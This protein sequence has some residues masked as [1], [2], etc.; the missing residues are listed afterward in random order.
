M[1]PIR[2]ILTSGCLF[3]VATLLACDADHPT[4]PG[5]GTEYDWSWSRPREIWPTSIWEAEDGT[6]WLADIDG[7]V[8]S[9]DGRAWLEHDTGADTLLHSIWTSGD[10]VYAVGDEGLILHYDGAA[11]SSTSAP[12]PVEL[13]EVW[14]TGPDDVWAVG[15]AGTLLHL[16]D[17][18]WQYHAT[19]N[20]ETL[21]AVWGTG[22]DDVY[23]GGDHGALYHFDGET[24]APLQTDIASTIWDLLG[25]DNGHLY[26]AAGDVWVR[27]AE[28]WTRLYEDRYCYTLAAIDDKLYVR[29]GGFLGQLVDNTLV[30]VPDQPGT[31]CRWLGRS[32]GDRILTV[33]ELGSV[34]AFQNEWATLRRGELIRLGAIEGT[35]ASD[36]YAVGQEGVVLHYDGQEWLREH[37]GTDRDLYAVWCSDTGRVFAVGYDVITTRTHGSWAVESS[38]DDHWLR[39]V[40]GLA[41]DDVY[42]GGM[43]GIILHYDGETW[44]PMETP[45]TSTIRGIWGSGPDDIFAVTR[46]YDGEVLHYD[47]Q[48]W[49]IQDKFTDNPLWSVWGTG[50]DNVYT[51]GWDG[52][53]IYHYDGE[54]W[55]VEHQPWDAT[56]HAVHG[57]GPD[58]VYVGGYQGG[59]WH[60]DGTGW[61]QIETALFEQ[62]TPDI[63]CAPDGQVFVPTS[64]G[65]VLRYGP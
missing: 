32:R 62:H 27:E 15:H 19:D 13:W 43:S 17:G 20:F 37:S 1:K 42:A 9:F 28:T 50:P 30:V 41:D 58:N 57:T 44:T 63:W 53:A 54:T 3:L 4:A 7:R 10:H 24:I 39:A 38:V 31:A 52:G 51:V 25:L 29:W 46:A 49:S 22:D 8:L 5:T 48:T 56:A 59:F 26:V 36:I 45:T 34:Y 21:Y 23:F 33:G 35:G 65:G 2:T 14:G 18:E 6:V 64:L 61:S 12:Y 16:T 47:G 40:W 11:W 60:F 55:H